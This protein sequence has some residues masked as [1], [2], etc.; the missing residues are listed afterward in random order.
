MLVFA[1]CVY[2]VVQPLTQSRTQPV[3][4]PREVSLSLQCGEKGKRAETTR[5]HR[6]SQR[7]VS[8]ITADVTHVSDLFPC[9][10]REPYVKL[11]SS[12]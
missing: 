8:D 2:C 7:T 4:S 3:A 10:I 1:P 5:M 6:A 9:Y 11:F 12:Q